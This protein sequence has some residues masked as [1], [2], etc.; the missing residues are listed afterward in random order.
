MSKRK[1]RS[2]IAI[3]LATGLATPLV[4]LAASP[5]QLD[6][7]ITV[8]YSD[9]NV[10]TVSGAKSLYSRLQRAS[11]EYCG[12]ES[13]GTVRSLP[14]LVDARACYAQTLSDAVASFD[15]VTLSRLHSS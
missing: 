8:S 13:Y 10:D 1:F 2:C 11:K 3:M 9:I 6:A 7:P 5:T 12:V 14:T 15:S 4:G